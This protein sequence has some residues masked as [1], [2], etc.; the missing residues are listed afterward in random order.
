M[1]GVG[2]TVEMAM[3]TILLDNGDFGICRGECGTTKGS[4][5]VNKGTAW[6]C[7]LLGIWQ[8]LTD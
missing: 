1:T 2:S 6:S 4:H 8:K 3:V 5:L 7:T